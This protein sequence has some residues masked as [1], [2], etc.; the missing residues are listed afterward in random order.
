MDT[1]ETAFSGL[2]HVVDQTDEKE[3][4]QFY[5]QEGVE[6]RRNIR[7]MENLY[8]DVSTTTCEVIAHTNRN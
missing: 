2:E 6:R 1:P 7:N 8:Y 3:I 4:R 5:V